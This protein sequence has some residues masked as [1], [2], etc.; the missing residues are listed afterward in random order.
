MNSCRVFAG[1]RG[2]MPTAIGTVPKLE[3]GVKSREW[4]QNSRERNELK[5]RVRTLELRLEDAEKMA[6]ELL[7]ND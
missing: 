3:I 4:N 1:M 2:L 7:E 6:M 5:Q